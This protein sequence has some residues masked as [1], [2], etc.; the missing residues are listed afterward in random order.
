MEKQFAEF[1][2][3]SYPST[4]QMK[5]LCSLGKALAFAGVLISGAAVAQM[6]GSDVNIAITKL[7]GNATA[8][9]ANADV[10]VLDKTQKEWAQTQMAFTV[11]D[12]KIRVDID[13][14]QMKSAALPA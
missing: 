3:K 2:A 10:R 11:L 7:F 6:P 5:T 8:F 9:S 4:T 13:M 1:D 14:T 12:G